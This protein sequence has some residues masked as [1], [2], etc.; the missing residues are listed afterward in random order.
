MATWTFVLSDRD[1]F[2]LWYA[3]R[4]GQPLK[5]GDGALALVPAVVAWVC[6]TAVP[7]DIIRGLPSGDCV[8]LTCPMGLTND[9]LRS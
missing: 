8:R 5:C 2:A 9:T 4:G 1:G 3:E 6:E 7:F